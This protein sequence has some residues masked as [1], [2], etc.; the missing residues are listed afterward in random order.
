MRIVVYNQKGGVGKTTTAINLGAALARSGAGLVS[1]V[2][3]DPQM[4]LTAALGKTKSRASYTVQD[5]L[6]GK[7]GTPVTIDKG[8]LVLVPGVPQ[9]KGSRAKLAM[10]GDWMVVD[11]P[12]THDAGVVRQLRQAD[13][14]L[15]PLEPDFLGLNGVNRLMRQ[16]EEAGIGWDRLRF[17]LCRYNTR[18]EV[19][20]EVRALLEHKFADRGMLPMVIRSSVKLAE[21]P[22][23]G[24]T[25]FEHAATSSGA[26]DY[27]ALASAVLEVKAAQERAA[28]DGGAT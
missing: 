8:K 26:K 21:A 27:I 12:P 23:K 11:A 3:F 16:M 24:Q 22:G 28:L 4:H 25:I 10:I 1:L 17:L 9:T 7:T 5:W 19:H 2:D 20:R 15:C 13:L 14:V 6:N 18:H